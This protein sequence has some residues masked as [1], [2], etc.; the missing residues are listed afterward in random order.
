MTRSIIVFIVLLLS[1]CGGGPSVEPVDTTMM[2]EMEATSSEL[3]DRINARADS[4]KGIIAELDMVFLDSPG[5][6]MT[7]FS[8]QLISIRARG[9]V[10]GSKLYL[11][12]HRDIDKLSFTLISDGTGS[13]L[14]IPEENT[15]Y[16]GPFDRAGPAGPDGIDIEA[17][18][19]A[20]ALYV[21]PF[22]P[23]DVAGLSEE[24]GVYILTLT[25]DGGLMRRLWIEKKMFTVVMEKYY[26]SLG[27]ED[28]VVRR[29]KHAISDGEGFPLELTVVKPGSGWEIS[30]IIRELELNPGDVPPGVFRFEVPPGTK[31]KRLE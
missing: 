3:I 24:S 20:K 6:Q 18:D 13:W 12:G 7:L 14:Y 11:E 25:R 31:V 1:G 10:E 15:V 19:L 28:L 17:A 2:P 4:T 22:R 16:T 5:G 21:E 8:G 26:D 9:P 23:S 29:S 30:L 27:V